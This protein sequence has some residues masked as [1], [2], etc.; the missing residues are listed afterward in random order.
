MENN[1]GDP[2]LFTMFVNFITTQIGNLLNWIMS[3]NLGGVSI[4]ILVIIGVIFRM[5]FAII[6][7]RKEE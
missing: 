7:R 2:R 3:L 1:I 4:A 6:G 5:V